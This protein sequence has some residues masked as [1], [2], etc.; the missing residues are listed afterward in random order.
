MNITPWIFFAES[1]KIV[2]IICLQ[3]QENVFQNTKNAILKFTHELC[4]YPRLVGIELYVVEREHE[5]IGI[6]PYSFAL[7]WRRSARHVLEEFSLV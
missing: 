6:K 1:I 4:F 2:N 5:S 7:P 3:V